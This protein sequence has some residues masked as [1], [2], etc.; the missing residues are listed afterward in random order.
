MWERR[1]GGSL[2]CTAIRRSETQ[3]TR[4]TPETRTAR[5]K[6][7]SR[8]SSQPAGDEPAAEGPQSPA[9]EQTTEQQP[10]SPAPEQAPVRRL[11]R[12]RT[13][14]VL[15]GVCGGIG[16]YFGVDPIVVR[17]VAVV[18]LLLGGAT[19][20]AYIAA[21]ILV[22]SE[23]EGG[24]RPPPARRAACPPARWRWS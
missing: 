21:M 3:W 4:L 20:V 11:F 10:Q 17:I 7:T 16:R 22:P 23:P 13:D 19:L 15:G 2:G 14:R 9:D 6:A 18:G 1:G 8:A 24:R 5:P 12:S